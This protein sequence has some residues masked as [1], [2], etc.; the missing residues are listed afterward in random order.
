MTDYTVPAWTVVTTMVWLTPLFYTL[1]IPAAVITITL[2]PHALHH[3]FFRLILLCWFTT[4]RI[5]FVRA[6]VPPNCYHHNHIYPA[7]TNFAF[8][9]FTCG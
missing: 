4:A 2:H 1:D 3:G 8:L 9:P 6:L 5:W 7:W